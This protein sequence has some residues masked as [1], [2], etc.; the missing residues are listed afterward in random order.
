MED[1]KKPTNDAYTGE[2]D[3]MDLDEDSVLAELDDLV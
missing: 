1:T 2:T 3:D